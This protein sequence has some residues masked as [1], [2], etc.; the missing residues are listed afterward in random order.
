MYL[1]NSLNYPKSRK[2]KFTLALISSVF[3]YL[4]LIFFQP[5]GVNN[6]QSSENITWELALG[7]IWIIPILFFTVSFNEFILRPKIIL[8]QKNTYLIAWFIYYFISVG[9]SSFLLYNYLGDFHVSRYGP[10]EATVLLLTWVIS[11]GH[12]KEVE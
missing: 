12:Y 9:T 5:F 1:Q 4:F 10:V 6:Y 3:I 2:F 11:N 7:L 8:N